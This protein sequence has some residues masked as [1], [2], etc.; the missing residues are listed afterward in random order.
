MPR[1]YLRPRPGLMALLA[2]GLVVCGIWS[3]L[4]LLQGTDMRVLDQHL[5][6][7]STLALDSTLVAQSFT[8]PRDNLSRIDLHLASVPDLRAGGRIRLVRGDG[9]GGPP[10]YEADLSSASFENNPF[11]TIRFPPIASSA[12]VSY[13]LVLE[14][15]GRPLSMSVN[16]M[17][18]PLDVLSSGRMYTADGPTDG[19][20]TFSLSY[21]YGLPWLWQD[22]LAVVAD[23]GT[24]VLAWLAVLMLPG[25]ALLVWLP[26]SLSAG[27]RLLAAPAVSALVLP[28]F[29]LIM[30]ALG[31]KTGSVGLWVVLAI[32]AAAL[33]ARRVRVRLRPRPRPATRFAALSAG[34]V[35]F[36]GLLVGV[37]AVTLVSRLASLRD[38]VAGMGLDAYHHTLIAMLFVQNGGIP[39]NYEPYAPLASFTYHYGFHALVATVAL[40]SGLTAP[41]DLMM[42]MP[43]TGQVAGALPVLTLTLFGWKT[44]GDRWAGLAGGALVGMVSVFPAFY[45]N[46]SRFT[47]GLGLAL[48]PVAWVLLLEAVQQPPSTAPAGHTGWQ[49]ALST[50]G[51]LMLAVLAATGLA[52]THYRV[53]MIYAGFAALYLPGCMANAVRLRS[54]RHALPVVQRM[55]LVT[56]LTVAAL[57]PWLVNLSQNFTT[58]FVGRDTPTASEYYSLK[59]LWDAGL[60]MHLSLVLML[61]LT[62]VGAVIWV[63]ERRNALALLPALTWGV[64]ALWSNPYLLPVRLPFAGYLDA[65]TLATGVWLPLS[66][67]AGYS[68]AW[69]GRRLVGVAD[70]YGPAV[71]RMWRYGTGALAGAVILSLGAVSGMALATMLDSKPYITQADLDALLWMRDHLPRNAYVLA[72]PF[73]FAWSPQNVHGSDAGLWVPLVTGGIRS[74]VPP[75]PAYNERP[76]DPGYLDSLR[77][78]VRYEPFA[79]QQPDWDALRAA[80]ITH[81]FVGSRGGALDVP[82]LLS[83][84]R[85]RLVFHRDGVWVFELGAGDQGSGAGRPR[86][87]GIRGLWPYPTPFAG[88][89]TGLASPLPGRSQVAIQLK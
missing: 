89:G 2:V 73:A 57:S 36:W 63:R 25:L 29:Y 53:V 18:S 83:S 33:I 85:V 86:R 56:V 11:L 72:N 74:S 6:T 28:V 51:P 3:A 30:R 17:Y 69:C 37:L 23:R 75:L 8:S 82:T 32:C 59:P 7:D 26:N 49:K 46:W 1:A 66:V 71:R 67:L 64:L 13:T 60:L 15:P 16:L 81:I 62:L 80:G 65:T 41:T 79:G 54:L 34:D 14:T 47:Q 45:V 88:H 43:Q 31:L 24:L 50:S 40:A 4:A 19:D 35:A 38:A 84:Q 78:V 76:N 10:V 22:L 9:P 87:S 12:G 77:N 39:S 5:G 48:L 27:Q 61:A 42:L 44:L 68:L 55:A 21:R 20:L 58:R 52:L 70:V